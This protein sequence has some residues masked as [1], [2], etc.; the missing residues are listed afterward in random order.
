MNMSLQWHR[1]GRR[2]ELAET[3]GG[4]LQA[5]LTPMGQGPALM[6]ADRTWRPQRKGLWGSA[7]VSG[8]P[9]TCPT[10]CFSEKKIIRLRGKEATGPRPPSKAVEGPGPRHQTPIFPHGVGHSDMGRDLGVEEWKGDNIEPSSEEVTVFSSLFST[11]LT[12]SRRQVWFGVDGSHHGWV[13]PM[14]PFQLICLFNKG[15]K[16]LRFRPFRWQQP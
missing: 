10:L 6:D 4:G 5:A 9:S 14:H 1:F 11:L 13:S 16:G 12:T 15:R 8:K 2:R 7:A 3:L